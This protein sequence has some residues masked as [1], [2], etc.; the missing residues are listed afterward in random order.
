MCQPETPVLEHVSKK[1]LLNYLIVGLICNS[2]WIDTNQYI[3]YY[4]RD[5]TDPCCVGSTDCVPGSICDMHGFIE[6]SKPHYPYFV[7]G[8]TLPQEVKLYGQGY[9]AKQCK[10]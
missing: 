7:A 10:I 9:A 5:N 4:L 3:M 8:E 2:S 6:A 1:Y